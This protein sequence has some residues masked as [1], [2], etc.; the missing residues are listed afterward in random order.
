MTSTSQHYGDSNSPSDLPSAQKHTNPSAL[1]LG[2][3]KK[4]SIQDPLVHCS[5]HFGCAVHTFCS[6]QTLVTNGIIHMG[7]DDTELLSAVEWKELA[8]FC[9]LLKMVPRLE[10]WLMESSE[11]EVISISDLIQKG[12]NGACADDTKGM[13]GAIIDWITP[14]GQSLTLHI[15]WNVK[16]GRGFNHERTGALLCPTGLDWNNTKYFFYSLPNQID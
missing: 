4:P 8:I 13:K 9:E 16:S 3:R 10:A 5:R 12:I 6:I 2:L 7:E 14:K 1:E 11:D 15:P